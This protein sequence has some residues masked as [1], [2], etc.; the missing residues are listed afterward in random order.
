[1]I[2][3]RCQV[4]TSRHGDYFELLAFGENVL[5]QIE[6]ISATTKDT[7]GD[8]DKVSSQLSLT[9]KVHP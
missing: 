1:M 6:G 2:P 4:P 5:G 7:E 3:G 8:T 9:I